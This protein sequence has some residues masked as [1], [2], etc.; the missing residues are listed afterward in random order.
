MPREAY[1]KIIIVDDTNTMRVILRTIL[2]NEGHEV[3]GQFSSGNGLI[4]KIGTLL[5]DI[6]CLDYHLPDT[7]GLNLLKQIHESYP[8]IAVVMITGEDS[9]EI[10]NAAIKN[11]SSG[12]IR[13]PFTPENIISEI[14]HVTLALGLLSNP[15]VSR[16]ENDQSN[17]KLT[18]VI[19]DDSKT[20]RMLLLS[21]LTTNNIKVVGQASDGKEAIEQYGIHNPDFI[22]LDIEMP[23][24][25]GIEALNEI[26]R[27]SQNVKSLIV[28]SSADRNNVMKAVELGAKG[29][30]IKPFQPAQVMEAITKLF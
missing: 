25:S 11:G 2:V 18:A 6:I 5:P 20:M 27:S 14:R 15:R 4:E 21:I 28:T 17:E 22:C 29:Y 19:A 13:K 10:Y 30:I 12:F 26:Y 23:I 16:S 7:N 24:M 9:I 8:N 1:S 3:V